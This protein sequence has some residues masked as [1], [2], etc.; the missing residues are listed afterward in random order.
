MIKLEILIM[1]FFRI[2]E[3]KL[4]RGEWIIALIGTTEWTRTTDPFHVKEVL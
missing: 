4:M 1:F 2:F 3:E